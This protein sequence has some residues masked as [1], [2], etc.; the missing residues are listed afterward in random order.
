MAADGAGSLLR[1]ITLGTAVTHQIRDNARPCVGWQ[2]FLLVMCTGMSHQCR[3]SRR[4]RRQEVVYL[5][6]AGRGVSLC[7]VRGRRVQN[8]V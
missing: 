2:E 1:C 3:M 5:R 8:R 6:Y 7:A 4:M